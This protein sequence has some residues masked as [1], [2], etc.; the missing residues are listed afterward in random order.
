M[1]WEMRVQTMCLTHLKMPYKLRV[2][3]IGKDLV[4]KHSKN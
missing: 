2:Q 3:G 1:I 4:E